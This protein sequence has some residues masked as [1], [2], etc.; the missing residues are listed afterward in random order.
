MNVKFEVHDGFIVY[1]NGPGPVLVALHAG[2]SFFDP[3][4]RDANAETVASLVWQKLGGTLVISTLPRKRKFGIDFNRALP[5]RDL[6]IKYY[7]INDVEKEYN[8]MKRYA[9]V[10]KD[11]KDYAKRARIYKEFW[12]YI[13]QAGNVYVFFHRKFTRMKNYPAI[14]DIV[15]FDGLGIDKKLLQAIVDEVNKEKAALMKGLEKDYKDAILLEQRRILKRLLKKYG[16]I[17]P[18]KLKGSAREYLLQDL[19]RIKEF[20]GI[21]LSGFSIKE[22]MKACK[23]ALQRGPTPHITIEKQFTGALAHGPRKELLRKASKVVIEVESDEFLNYWH[24]EETAELVIDVLKKILLVKSLAVIPQRK[25]T[26]FLR[27]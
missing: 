20:A 6:A 1:K 9:F 10:A 26:E 14:F 27:R 8:Y 15:T 16:T 23:L 7:N 18:L 22:F 4:N 21:T 25:I 5:P 19:A 13:R 12:S 24:P 17:N 3:K 11:A 2:P